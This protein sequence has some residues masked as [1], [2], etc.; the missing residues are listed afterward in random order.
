MDR[1]RF[2]DDLPDRQARIEGSHR[3]LE[4][5]LELPAP[6]AEVAAPEADEV[7]V[8]EPDAAAGDGNQAEDGASERGFSAAAFSDETERFAGWDGQAQAVHGTHPGAGPPPSVGMDRV[9]NVELID[10]EQVHG[11]GSG[12]LR[13]RA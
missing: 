5:H 10:F 9:M 13:A 4:D 1:E 11:E 7:F 6:L 12:G 8:G 2:A 3:I